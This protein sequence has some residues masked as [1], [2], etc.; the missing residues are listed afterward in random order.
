[1]SI[2]LDEAK[3][4]GVLSEDLLAK[5]PG[6]PIETL[7]KAKGPVVMIE[8][9]QEIPCNPCET[10]CPSGAITVGEPITNLPIVDAEKCSGCGMCIAICPG[11]AVFLADMNQREGCGSV[12][13]PYEYLPVPKE[14]DVVKALDREGKVVCDAK[15]ERVLSPPKY[16]MTKVVTILVPVEHVN[17]VRGIERKKE[18]S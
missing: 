2:D 7:K 15:V 17:T 9:A 3:T 14:G 5:T 16:D 18:V 4:N 11:L 1:M 6:F 10:V 8:C 12:S 13:F